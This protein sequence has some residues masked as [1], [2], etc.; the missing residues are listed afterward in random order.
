VTAR[1][2]RGVADYVDTAD[3]HF[4]AAWLGVLL[5]AAR[6]KPES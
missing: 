1:P 5:K 2:L 3:C 4:D 6:R